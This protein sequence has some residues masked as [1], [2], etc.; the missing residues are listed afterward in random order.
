MKPSRLYLPS[1][2]NNRWGRRRQ[3]LR[4][5]L[6]A[7]NNGKS[8]KYKIP[9]LRPRVVVCVTLGRNGMETKR[10]WQRI[11]KLLPTPK[12]ATKKHGGWWRG[13]ALTPQR[14]QLARA[15]R[16]PMQHTATI[17][18]LF[19]LFITLSK[20]R[21]AAQ[22]KETAALIEKRYNPFPIRWNVSNLC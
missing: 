5:V 9:H 12:V 20:V 4:T 16:F 6:L 21:R 15:N 22:I 19:S 7:G 10:V 3:N 8:K 17:F 1:L 18:M 2:T 14:R 11:P 13:A